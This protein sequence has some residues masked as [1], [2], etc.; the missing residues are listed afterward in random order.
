[1]VHVILKTDKKLNGEQNMSG[2]ANVTRSQIHKESFQQTLLF[3]QYLA[4]LFG[5]ETK[6]LSFQVPDIVHIVFHTISVSKM[7]SF[8]PNKL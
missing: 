8:K 7:F 3:L 5:N 4:K 6:L 1:M 2:N